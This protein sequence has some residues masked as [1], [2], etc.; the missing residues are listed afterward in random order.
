MASAAF[1]RLDAAQWR[2]LFAGMVIAFHMIML[3]GGYRSIELIQ[4][5]RGFLITHEGF[6]IGLDAVPMAICMISLNI[7]HPG[8]AFP[9]KAVSVVVPADVYQAELVGRR[10]LKRAWRTGVMSREIQIL[11]LAFVN[12]LEREE[13]LDII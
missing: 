8:W 1:S 7:C 3:R 4:G 9:A 12:R 10:A 11:E 13:T 2:L 5:W 6:F